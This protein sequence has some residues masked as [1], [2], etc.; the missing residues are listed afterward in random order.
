MQVTT[1]SKSISPKKK[2]SKMLKELPDDCSYEDIQYHLYVLQK[3]EKG[4]TDIEEGRTYSHEEA[5]KKLNKWL[6][7]Y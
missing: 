4:V 3:I 5:G 1:K 6:Q 7:H 2:A